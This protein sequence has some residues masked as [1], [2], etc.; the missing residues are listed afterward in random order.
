MKKDILG[1]TDYHLFMLTKYG[2]EEFLSMDYPN[3]MPAYKNLLSND[4]IISVLSYIKSKWPS[5]IRI[6]HDQLNKV[7]KEN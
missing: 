6:K 4:Q 1:T 7:F 3:N 2:I 5:H